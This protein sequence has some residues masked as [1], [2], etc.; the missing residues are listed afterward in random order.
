[1]K[2]KDPNYIA[3]VEKA[4][5]NKYG[6]ETIRNPRNNWDEEKEKEYL[7]QLKALALKE[8]RLREKEEKIDVGGILISKKLLNREPTKSCQICK[9]YSLSLKDDVYMN[10]YECC[11]DCFIQFVEGREERWKKGWRPKENG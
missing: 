2:K 10:K 5:A 9:R 8:D 6:E 7:E 1:M 11:H 3:K 4:I